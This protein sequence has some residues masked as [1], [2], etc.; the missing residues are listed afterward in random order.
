MTG[1]SGFFSWVVSGAAQPVTARPTPISVADPVAADIYRGP[2]IY[3]FPI[4]YEEYANHIFSTP[5][6]KS[7]AF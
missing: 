2:V 7:T 3:L 6:K 1:F 5:N 4:M